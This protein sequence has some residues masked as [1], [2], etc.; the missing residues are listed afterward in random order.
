MSIGI[1]KQLLTAVLLA[2]AAF[3]ILLLP[4]MFDLWPGGFRWAHPSQHPAYEHMIIAIYFALGVCLIPA[5]FD[6]QRHVLLINF[7]ILSSVLHGLVMAYDA[8]AQEHE[9]I[10]LVGD[11]PI[12]FLLAGVLIWLHP[13]WWATPDALP[14][15]REQ[16][17]SAA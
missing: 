5:A 16:P 6:P 8:V 10:H 2:T 14:A 12:L 7:T 17:R 9:L 11:V 13:R 3:L 1:K 15:A 4:F